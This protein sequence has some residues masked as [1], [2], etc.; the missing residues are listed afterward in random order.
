VGLRDQQLRDAGVADIKNTNRLQ[1]VRF[2][3]RAPEAISVSDIP[4]TSINLTYSV[5]G[6][7]ILPQM[8]ALPIVRIVSGRFIGVGVGVGVSRGD[9]PTG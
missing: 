3:L 2:R 9:N 7:L 4:V 1:A 8:L 5:A 6:S